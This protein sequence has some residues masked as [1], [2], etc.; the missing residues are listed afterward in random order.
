[1]LSA[2]DEVLVEAFL[3]GRIGFLDIPRG[4]ERVLSGHR[5]FEITALEDARRADAEGR[6]AA[7]AFLA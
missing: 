2:A 1:V 5:A 3:G 7:R 4:L 6:E